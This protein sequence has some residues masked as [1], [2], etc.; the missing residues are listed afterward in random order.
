[1]DIW[2]ANSVSTAYTPHPCTV[3]GQTRCEGSN[4]G[5]GDR[6]ASLCDADGCDFN[7]YRMGDTS[8]YGK[9]LTLD[10]SKPMTGKTPIL[11][12]Y[13][14]CYLIIF[15]Q[16]LPNSSVV[17]DKHLVPYRKSSDSTFRTERWSRTPNPP[18]PMFLVTRS[19]IHSVPLKRP[20]L[21]IAT[22]LKIEEDLPKWA[23]LL[24][25]EWFL[26]CPSGMIIP[27][28]C[29]GLMH[30]THQ[31][32]IHQSQVSAVEPAPQTL[33]SQLMSRKTLQVLPL[34]TPTSNGV[35]LEAHS[36][37]LAPNCAHELILFVKKVLYISR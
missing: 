35:L 6:Y 1:M 16:L 10:T 9:G 31:P 7:S 27:P 28:I 23:K 4:C 22:D 30:L 36:R 26:S 17:T 11:F 33:E 12:F 25:T 18:S 3:S 20:P 21:A 24:P 34:P 37:L 8:F 29:F 13:R 15:F 14:T 19:L 32:R 2:E 5:V